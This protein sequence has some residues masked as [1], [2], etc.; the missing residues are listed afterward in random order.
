MPLKRIQTTDS[1]IKIRQP[2]MRD[3]GASNEK[4]SCLWCGNKLRVKTYTERSEPGTGKLKAPS[5][6]CCGAGWK[7]AEE[8]GYF[9]CRG[10]G[11][12]CR[13]EHSRTIIKR[14]PVY[15][16][17]AA[18]DYGDNAFCGLHCGYAFGVSMAG[19]GRRF[20]S[21]VEQKPDGDVEGA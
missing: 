9:D 5:Y 7:K 2:V 12:Q 16:G 17:A 10:C 18:G 11:H 21:V 1:S 15:E 8:P 19:L 3:F 13:G 4:G 20:Q 6:V 14:T